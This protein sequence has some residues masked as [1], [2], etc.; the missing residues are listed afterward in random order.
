VDRDPDEAQHSQA[1]AGGS[2]GAEPLTQEEAGEQHGERRRGLQDQ[3]REP[4]RHAGGHGEVQEHE[5]QDA[6]PEPVA[7]DP[8]P[9]HRWAPD[10]QQGRDGDQAEA[11]GD[12]E[13]RRELLERQVD[14]GEVQPPAQCHED[15]EEAVAQRHVS[16]HAPH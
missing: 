12:E 6:E 3:R 2:R 7:E 8:P 4:G 9:R 10:E 5:L 11:H 15:G 13:E 1:D 14:R 16:E